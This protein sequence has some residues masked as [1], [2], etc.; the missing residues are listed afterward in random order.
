MDPRAKIVEP[1]RI[2]A[3]AVVG[4]VTVGPLSVVGPNARIERDFV[5]SVAWANA[6]A[7][8]SNAT[9]TLVTS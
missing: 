5:R 4:P 9:E 7:N 6:T 1:V 3:G 8:A 2:C